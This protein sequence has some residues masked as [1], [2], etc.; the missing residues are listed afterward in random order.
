VDKKRIIII[1]SI[2][3]LVIAIIIAVALKKGNSTAIVASTVA[4]SNKTTIAQIDT[5][6]E[7]V[8]YSKVQLTKTTFKITEDVGFS[9]SY[10]SEIKE[11]IKFT[12]YVNPQTQ[13][14]ERISFKFAENNYTIFS[15]IISNSVADETI[16]VKINDYYVTVKLGYEANVNNEFG[17]QINQIRDFGFVAINYVEKANL[18]KDEVETS[19][20]E[21]SA[22]S[23][24]T[25][26]QNIEDIQT[27]PNNSSSTKES[28]VV[29]TAPPTTL[30]PQLPS[31][32]SNQ[33]KKY[34][35]PADGDYTYYK[36]KNGEVIVNLDLAVTAG[37]I[38]KDLADG[39][40]GRQ[41]DGDGYTIYYFETP[42]NGLVSINANEMLYNLLK[43][44]F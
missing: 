22:V 35:I 15:Y 4:Q 10:P 8:D 27:V 3:V 23:T 18:K 24:I 37:V 25:L 7:T 5:P 30:L 40:I 17:T 1:G 28:Q 20:E 39:Y 11:L 26:P 14:L 38:S 12:K 6:K 9:V 42:T 13:T 32:T 44:N 36:M 34:P 33:Y 19:I 29:I 31:T 21:E 43:N 16:A 2:V 41:I